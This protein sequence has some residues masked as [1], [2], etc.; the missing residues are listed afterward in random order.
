MKVVAYMTWIFFYKAVNLVNEFATIVELSNFSYNVV[1]VHPVYAYSESQ[2]L[3]ALLVH[4]K[5][6]AQLQ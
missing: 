2:W 5:T 1:F 3:R 4:A 6:R